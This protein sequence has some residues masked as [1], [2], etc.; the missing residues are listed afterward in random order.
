MKNKNMKLQRGGGEGIAAVGGLMGCL[1]V[2][3]F[4]ALQVW[5]GLARF[6]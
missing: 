1:M 5:F 6:R 4:I 3:G 2:V